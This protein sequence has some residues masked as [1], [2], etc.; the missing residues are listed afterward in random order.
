MP[1]DEAAQVLVVGDH[2]GDVHL[3]LAAAPAVQ[4]V[5][6]AMVLLAHQHHQALLDGGI[7]QLP[8]HLELVRQSR[9]T[10]AELRRIER[11]RIGAYL[12]AHEEA[13]RLL[14]GVVAR[15]DDEAAVL[16][17]EAGDR[18][19][20]AGTVGA[21]DG[22][23]V[24]MCGAHDYCSVGGVGSNFHKVNRQIG[25]FSTMRLMIGEAGNLVIHSLVRSPWSI[26]GRE[27][28]RPR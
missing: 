9:E 7:G 17:D 13:L 15:L 19:D 18:G 20:D 16:R 6:Q 21:G 1:L 10:A 22:E 25:L 4:Q 2:A 24:A 23:G 3:Q 5:V 28:T 27:H 12:L 11:Q 14:L 8:G 26:S